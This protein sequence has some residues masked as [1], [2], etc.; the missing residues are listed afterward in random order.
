MIRELVVAAVLAS[1][2]AFGQAPIHGAGGA[3][4]PAINSGKPDTAGPTNDLQMKSID[5]VLHDDAKLSAKLKDM[6]PA[7]MTPQQACAGFKTLEQCVTAIHVAQNLKVP[8]ADLKA[9]TT[10][11]G[12][13]SMQKAIEQ[14]AANVNA[15]DEAKKAKKQAAEDMKG[16]NLF[17]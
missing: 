13:V 3:G 11:K 16:T 9:K 14:M 12:S 4:Q 6:L 1:A 7:E 17:G 15:K 10:G 8:F 2:L 5:Q